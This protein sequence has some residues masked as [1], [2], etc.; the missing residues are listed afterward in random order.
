MNTNGT[1]GPSRVGGANQ[2]QAADG[3]EQSTGASRSQFSEFISSTSSA[4]AA[5]PTAAEKAYEVALDKVAAELSASELPLGTEAVEEVI[6]VAVRAQFEGRMNEAN[7]AE[8]VEEAVFILGDDP[9][10][11]PATI[12]QLRARIDEA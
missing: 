7:L 10:F 11:A 1:D 5:A 6:A 12:D 9:H 8:I 4:D 3:A 2:A